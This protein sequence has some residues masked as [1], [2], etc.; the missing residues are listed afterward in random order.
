M[1]LSRSFPTRDSDPLFLMFDVFILT[2]LKFV[3]IMLLRVRQLIPVW[4][5]RIKCA[6]TFINLFMAVRLLIENGFFEGVGFSPKKGMIEGS[7][8][9]VLFGIHREN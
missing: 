8:F 3:R 6:V 4:A 7:V 9:L 1:F 2:L 5:T